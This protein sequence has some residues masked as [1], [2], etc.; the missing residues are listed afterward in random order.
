MLINELAVFATRFNVPASAAHVL[1]ALF[2]RSAEMAGM[3]TRQLVA[4]ATYN[5]NELGEYLAA[6]AVEVAE[7]DV[8]VSLKE[9]TA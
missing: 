7:V 1:P 6:K 5:N 3:A 8:I 2:E 4:T 9:A